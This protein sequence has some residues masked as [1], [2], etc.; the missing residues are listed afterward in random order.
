VDD[1]YVA[2]GLGGIIAAGEP[3]MAHFGAALLAAW[4]FERDAQLPAETSMAMGSQ[5]D[6]MIAKHAWLFQLLP[7]DQ[8]PQADRIDELV[9][10]ITGGL[11]HAWAIGHDVIYAA[12]VV[13][14][15]QARPEFASDAVIDG[16]LSVLSACRAFPID[17]IGGSFSVEGVEADEVAQAEVTTDRALAE[18][19]LGAIV[20]SDHV[21][22]GVHQGDLGHVPDHAHALIVL[23]RLG[24]HRAAQCG[25]VGFREH[26][27][28]LRRARHFTADLPEAR[29]RER[30]DPVG[31][32]YWA[33]GSATNDWALGHLFK[34][35]YAILDLLKRT[36]ETSL[37]EPV[38]DR[39]QLLV[40]DEA[41]RV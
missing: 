41:E 32:E 23:E 12:L 40:T 14:T 10:A 21:Y 6:S 15:L 36:G 13:R 25:R 18:A 27:A 29:R 31:I 7:S 5:A 22:V 30:A 20:V 19:A 37:A 9:D 28:A 3:F 24:Y 34:Y 26:L 4:W 39:L 38:L 11:D 1:R 17:V 8:R 2:L 33:R 35:P 16:V